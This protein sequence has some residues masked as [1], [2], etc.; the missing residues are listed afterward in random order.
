MTTQ[1]NP[2]MLPASER[3]DVLKQYG[4]TE[5]LCREEERKYMTTI[6]RSR[7]WE[8]EKEG[9]FP[10]RHRLGNSSCAW[11]LS[12]L[13]NWIDRQGRVEE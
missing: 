7:A 5:K 6:S 8:L 9:L 12:E 13:L 10:P 4:M 3:A 2:F 1:N 11:R